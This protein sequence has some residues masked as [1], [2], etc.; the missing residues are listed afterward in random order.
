MNIGDCFI[1]EPA[2]DLPRHLWIIISDPDVDPGN[3]L[4]VNVTSWRDFH[5]QACV[6]NPGDHER[7][8]EKSCVNYPAA[9]VTSAAV[10]QD[11]FDK[12]L[13][14]AQ[15]PCRQDILNR[16]LQGAYLSDE[17]KGMHKKLLRDQGL[18]D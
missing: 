16:I 13:V 5:D 4:I 15:P 8:H 9:K 2:H 17:I 14:H 12:R 10:L 3:I 18:I 7:I 6:L 1:N 11:A